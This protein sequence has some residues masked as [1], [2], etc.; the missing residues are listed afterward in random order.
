MSL[1]TISENYFNKDEYNPNIMISMMKI[2]L[3]KINLGL[4]SYYRRYIKNFAQIALPLY[5]LLQKNEPW[6]WL[7]P[8]INSNKFRYF[9]RSSHSISFFE[10]T[11]FS[12]KI[13]SFHGCLKSCVRI[14]SLPDNAEY[15]VMY[16][17]RS[18]KGAEIHY[19]ITE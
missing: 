17:S 12:L 3:M 1:R 4:F 7:E 8:Q 16:G 6:V 10:T 9:E 2:N 19:G 11:R 18:L 15:V 14:C 13:F 5:K